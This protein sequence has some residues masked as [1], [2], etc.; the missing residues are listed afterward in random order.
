MTSEARLRKPYCKRQ[1]AASRSSLCDL[2][3][4]DWAGICDGRRCTSTE[5]DSASRKHGRI[6]PYTWHQSH[7][8]RLSKLLSEC[9]PLTRGLDFVLRQALEGAATR[10]LLRVA[11]S[12]VISSSD[13]SRSRP[14]HLRFRKFNQTPWRAS[15][16]LIERFEAL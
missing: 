10:K 15:G 12:T 4:T 9:S 11:S 7:V 14:M 3:R 8:V 1:F 13:T 2:L 6:A 16:C 5:A